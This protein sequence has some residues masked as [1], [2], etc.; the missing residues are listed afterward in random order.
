[1]RDVAVVGFAQSP[2]ARSELERNEVE[3]LMP[4]I[5]EAIERA[6]HPAEGD[7]LHGLRQLRLPRRAAVRVRDRAR[8]RR[9]VAADPRVARRDGRRVGAVR[10]VGAPPARRHRLGAGVRVRQVVARRHPRRADAAARP[11]LHAAALARQRQHRGAAGAGAARRRQDDRARHGGGRRAHPARCDGR[12]RRRRSP[13]T[14]TSRCAARASR[15]SSSPLRKHDCP[16]ISDGAAAIVLAAGDLARQR[17]RSGRR[18]SAASTIASSRTALGMRD[19]TQSPSTTL[20]GER[21]GV[22][23]GKVDVAELHAPFSHQEVILR[24]AL[25]LDG[26]RAHQSVRRRAGRERGDGRR[27]GAHRRGGA[28]RSS[29]GTRRE[30]SPTRRRGRACSRTWCA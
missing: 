1:M 9:R 26:G 4:V 5:R 29:T 16:P 20:A 3:M 24:E 6:R 25:G 2:Y 17:V 10:G 18:G 23:E 30:R 13:A 11:V 28:A 27:S 14:S 21:A 7:R 12:T 15:T 8:R 22:G 19:L